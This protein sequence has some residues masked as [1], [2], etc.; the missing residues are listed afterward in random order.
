[1]MAEEIVAE[2]WHR[3][4]GVYRF[5]PDAIRWLESD[6]MKG[7]WCMPLAGVLPGLYFEF[8]ED[9]MQFWMIWYETRD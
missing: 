7:R 8:E 9:K 1:M 4:P 3:V 5:N 2:T 6:A